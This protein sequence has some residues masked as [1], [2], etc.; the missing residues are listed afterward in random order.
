MGTKSRL[1][2]SPQAVAT[3]SKPRYRDSLR[4]PCAHLP[5]GSQG[6]VLLSPK[7]WNGRHEGEN[8]AIEIACFTN[9]PPLTGDQ[10]HTHTH[11]IRPNRVISQFL[12]PLISEKLY[13]TYGTKKSSLHRQSHKSFSFCTGTSIG[14][15][16]NLLCFTNYKKA[17][18][19]P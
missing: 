18:H 15:Q 11:T 19:F 10:T 8:L 14:L 7:V 5:R 2:N 17:S 6:V 4:P 9:P 1:W 3:E 16:Q 12:M 13:L